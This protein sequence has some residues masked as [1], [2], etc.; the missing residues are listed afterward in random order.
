MC[1]ALDTRTRIDALTPDRCPDIPNVD[2]KYPFPGLRHEPGT[3]MNT[4]VG[5]NMLAADLTLIVT[6]ET[7]QPPANVERMIRFCEKH[8]VEYRTTGPSGIINV[9][10]EFI[11]NWDDNVLRVCVEGE[12]EH[13][14]PG[15]HLDVCRALEAVINPKFE[16]EPVEGLYDV[17]NKA[18]RKQRESPALALARRMRDVGDDPGL[19]LAATGVAADWENPWTV[20][21]PRLEAYTAANTYTVSRGRVYSYGQT[22]REPVVP[23]N[24]S[25]FCVQCNE[26]IIRMDGW[27]C[28]DCLTRN[29]KVMPLE[30]V[31]AN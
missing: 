2:L 9:M 21:T 30:T 19:L 24:A 29:N 31:K 27:V 14:H 6:H 7:V 25:R 12:S 28:V 11:E 23:L 13:Q 18:A 10:R 20:N 1:A 4:A 26:T 5:R 8:N 15:T 22:T 16:F 3:D 17:I